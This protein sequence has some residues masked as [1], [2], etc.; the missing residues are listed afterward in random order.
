MTRGILLRANDV[1]RNYRPPQI[2]QFDP[3]LEPVPCDGCPHAVTCC[4]RQLACNAFAEYVKTGRWKAQ[5][6]S[7]LPSRRP[8]QKLFCH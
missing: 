6:S 1:V 3:P 7:R 2:Q 4:S 8:F 5:P